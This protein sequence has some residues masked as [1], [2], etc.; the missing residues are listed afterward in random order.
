[1]ENSAV[2]MELIM[3]G[4]GVRIISTEKDA[5]STLTATVMMAIGLKIPLV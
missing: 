1:M 5:W 3:L 4:G 2:Q